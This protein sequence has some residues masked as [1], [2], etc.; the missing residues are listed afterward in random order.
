[1]QIFSG[2]IPVITLFKNSQLDS[3]VG[4]AL[5]NLAYKGLS[6]G[7]N[8]A[9]GA[10]LANKLRL[11][12]TGDSN[13]LSPIV[14]PNIVNSGVAG[15]SQIVTTSITNSKALGPLGP[16]AGNL[17]NEGI[18]YLGNEA[19]K[20]IFGKLIE[21]GGL[22]KS[23]GTMYFPGANDEDPAANYGKNLPK[24]L[25]SPNLLDT[26]SQYTLGNGG[27][28]VVFSIVPAETSAVGQAQ[29]A[30][31]PTGEG[32]STGV[33]P[34]AQPPQ[35]A[36]PATG[37]AAPPAPAPTPV[38]VPAGAPGAGN[39]PSSAQTSAQAAAPVVAASAALPSGSSEGTGTPTANKRAGESTTAAVGASNKTATPVDPKATT[40]K[41]PKSVGWTFICPPKEI[42]WETT[43]QA[44][45][46]PIFGAN[47]APVM[48]GTKGMRDLTLN[49]AIV[50]GFS[51][52]KKVE[53]KVAA[54]ELLLKMKVGSATQGG[55][56]INYIQIPVY[57]VTA[58]SKVYGNVN[59]EGGFFVI[60]SIKV[61]ENLR[62]LD[63]N[64]T[65]ATVDV[66]LTQVPSYQVSTGRDQANPALLSKKGPFAPI[67]DRLFEQ[68]IKNAAA[69]LAA[70]ANQGASAAA[71]PGAGSPASPAPQG[72]TPGEPG[73]TVIQGL[74]PNP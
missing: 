27:P 56:K 1:M 54:L 13:F 7:V 42:S 48:G 58:N 18:N 55:N 66:T 68:S 64:S 61:Q 60:K 17:V 41:A 34:P 28:D 37:N 15:L 31:A 12:P 67:A 30:T 45:R 9:L 25:L 16:L 74:N 50:E 10:E 5:T 2:V 35:G 69:G 8:Q 36:N 33:A 22:N 39:G 59:N 65:R 51:R 6:V 57:R 20:K 63:G 53:A 3:A 32:T 49:E 43:A 14:S 19:V 24:N 70:Q 73:A 21:E 44:D 11:G 38:N 71:D 47:S 4:G 62:D 29:K 26:G 52:N 40:G 23:K 46:V 72:V